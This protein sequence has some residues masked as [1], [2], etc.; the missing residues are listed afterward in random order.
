MKNELLFVEASDL[1]NHVLL[2]HN[3]AKSDFGS[4]LTEK[5]ISV[6]FSDR[7]GFFV[8]PISKGKKKNSLRF[9]I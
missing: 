6:G 4:D 1:G 5:S 7:S 3:L 2:Q 8:C 9:V